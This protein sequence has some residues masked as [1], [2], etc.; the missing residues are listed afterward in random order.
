M[1]YTICLFQI[2]FLCTVAKLSL[3]H[4]IC[5]VSYILLPSIHRCMQSGW[6]PIYLCKAFIHPPNLS[7][8]FWL[9]IPSNPLTLF[10][11]FS[12]QTYS[13]SR[14]FLRCHGRCGGVFMMG[15]LPFRSTSLP[16]CDTVICKMCF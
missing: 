4:T 10:L 16:H 11:R 6:F 3:M 2:L 8:S 13:S 9:G 15:C 14:L 5:V 7:S 12:S 1:K